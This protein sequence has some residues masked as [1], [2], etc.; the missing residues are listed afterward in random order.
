MDYLVTPMLRM[1]A[2]ISLSLTL[3]LSL[4]APPAWAE[5][6]AAGKTSPGLPFEELRIFSEVYARIR[7]DYVETVDDKEL[8]ENAIRGMLTGLDPHSSY[9]GE[10]AWS[11]LKEG[12]EGHFGGLGIE[13]AMDDGL[14]KVI[15][16]MDDTPAD[17]AGIEAGDR[18]TRIDN[19]PVKGMTLTDAVDLMR[20]DPGTT[21]K[22]TIMRDGSPGLKTVTI[23]RDIIQV[24][25]VKARTLEPGYLYVRVANFQEKTTHDL[26]AALDKLVKENNGQVR[27]VVLDLRNNPG[28]L[29]SSAVGVADVFLTDGLIVYTEGRV[30]DS[31]LKFRVQ[32]PMDRIDGAPMVVLVNGG[33]ASASEIVAGAL[34]DQK[35]AIIVGQ[36]TFGKGSVQTIMP[37]KSGAE[38]LKITTALYFTPN[39]RSIQ[40]EGI[41]PDVPLERVELSNIDDGEVGDIKE[42]DLSGHLLN[43]NGDHDDDENPV[44]R[45]T[46]KA[47]SKGDKGGSLAG[48]DFALYEALNLLKGMSLLHASRQ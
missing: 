36:P 19:T 33:S 31:N 42:S 17:R 46:I 23:E 16:P 32:T 43:G 14:I 13:V 24:Q 18:I 6:A 39:G 34:Q 7:R 30:K 5:G 15:A 25:S 48:K 40:A 20:G 1:P 26:I 2:I 4:S 29:L 27:G 41:I 9:L 21:I 22:L 47:P 45:V 3:L 28:G 38:A 8:I 12:T 11:E 10:D 44:K 37:M 35:R